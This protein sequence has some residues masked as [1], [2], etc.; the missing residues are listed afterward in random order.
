MHGVRPVHDFRARGRTLGGYAGKHRSAA[1]LVW[2]VGS[3]PTVAPRPN[4]LECVQARSVRFAVV[5]QS[6][7]SVRGTGNQPT[8]NSVRLAPTPE[9]PARLVQTRRPLPMRSQC[10]PLSTWKSPTV[11]ARSELIES[12]ASRRPRTTRGFLRPYW[13]RAC[14]RDQSRASE[15][16]C[17]SALKDE[18]APSIPGRSTA[19]LAQTG[20]HRRPLGHNQRHR[21]P[22]RGEPDQ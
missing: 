22:P 12:P 21:K 20:Q 2:A 14:G 11:R 6:S 9:M 17:L 3:E 15:R 18:R 19:L 4:M 5:R 1:L 16:A 7:E 8:V 10:V 13:S